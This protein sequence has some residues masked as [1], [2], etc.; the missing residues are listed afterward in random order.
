MSRIGRVLCIVMMGVVLADMALA[1]DVPDWEN[2]LVYGINKE[3]AH[4]TSV[5][6]AKE[7]E[8]GKRSS[9]TRSLD[10]LWKF[11]WAAKPED[12]PIDFYKL[13]Y[14]V[15]DWDDIAVPSNWQRKGYG[16]PVYTN[17]IYPF[18][19]E[20][21]FV[22]KEPPKHY[23]SYELRNPVGSY[24]R[25]FDV[26][27]DWDGKQ[28]FVHFDGVKSTFYLWVNGE[29]V[30]Y[31][32]GSFT[33]AEFDITEYLRDGENMMAVEVYRWSDG[34][35]LEDQDFWRLSGI[36]RPVRLVARNKVAIQDYFVRTD[37]DEE[38]EDAQLQVAVKL[39]NYGDADTAGWTVEGKLLDAEKGLFGSGEI[40]SFA[41][42]EVKVDGDS[43]AEVTFVDDI[44]SPAKWSAEK[45]YLYQLVLT[46]KDKHGKAVEV[47]SCD[48][49]F[50]E[51]E[52]GPN[53][54]LLV[55][56]KSVLLKGV[57]RHEHDPDR[58]RSLTVDS[59]IEDLRLMKLH[60]INCVRTSHYPNDPRWYSLCD[61]YGIYLVDEANIEGHGMYGHQG[62]PALGERRDWDGTH[63]DRAMSMVHRDKNHPS[64]IF[65]SFGNESGG[66]KAFD[67]IAKAIKAVDKTRLLHYEVYWEPADMDSNMYPS[68]GWV[69]SQGKR[70][71]NRPYFVCE[72]A[73][74][75]GN[76]VGNLQEYWDVIERYPRC[77]GACIW[78]WVDQGLRETDENGK[79]YFTY[80]GDY[81]DRPNSGN[82]CINGLIL[83]DR[84]V[85]PKLIEVKQV[86]QY[87]DF[88]AIDAAAG[89]I[90]IANEY[91]FTNLSDFD[92]AWSIT[93][94]GAIVQSGKMHGPDIS[95]KASGEVTLP[96]RQFDA[97]K[98]AEYLLN[99]KLLQRQASDFV[100]RGHTVAQG[101][102]SIPV[103][104]GRLAVDRSKSGDVKVI[105]KDGKIL[106]WG[107]GFT[108]AFSREDATIDELIY[109]GNVVI[110]DNGDGANGPILNAFRAPVDNDNRGNWYRWGLNELK[111]VP[112]SVT[113]DK[114]GSDN[115]AITAVCKYFGRDELECFEV[116]SKYTVF[117]D[118][119]ILVRNHI[120]PGSE[121]GVL[122]RLGMKMHVSGD[123]ENVKWY[124]RGPAENYP[125]RKTGSM[126]GL[127]EST[128]SDQY[129][130]YVRPQTT[131]NKEDVRWAALLNDSGDGV[132]AVSEDVMS[133]TA[134]RYTENE[135]DRAR[136]INELTPR[137]D[138]VVSLDYKQLGLGNGSCGPG[139]LPKYSFPAKTVDFNF[140]LRPY[141][142]TMDDIRKAARGTLT[143][144]KPQVSQN[145]QGDIVIKAGDDV[146]ILYTTDGSDPDADSTEYDEPIEI[147]RRTTVK[148]VAVA[149]GFMASPVASATFYEKLDLVDAG[150]GKWKVVS[151]D[152]VHPGEP[153]S[154]AI[155]GNPGTKWHTEWQNASPPHPHEIVIDM[156]TAYEL[157]G[158][159]LL[160]RQDGSSNGSIKGYKFFVSDDGQEWG[161]PA[162]EG[163]M[164][165]ARQLNTVR[166]D[167]R[168][169]GRYIK[170]VAAS[171]F[172]GPW[173][174][175]AELDVLAT[176]RLD[177]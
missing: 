46:L 175:V 68:I 174:S 5:P 73:H 45:P 26:P 143:V 51:I 122:P 173:T 146:I 132:I 99:V 3:P 84:Q 62:V 22:T 54:Q 35:Y 94:D 59:M 154:N 70:D 7:S 113:V 141:S 137:D 152:S 79:E 56:G 151:V 177:Q 108:M 96:V 25:T 60:N 80:G 150:K 124:G 61:K 148:A 129:V 38:Y 104:M 170:L 169:N 114:G 30:G 16:V 107:D 95:P 131:G 168:V 47:H 164:E 50:R 140:S 153:G 100:P 75:M 157:A 11:H 64:V 20:P 24:R 134:L 81:G 19:K 139:V 89:R 2:P 142:R 33:P 144:P 105:E 71:S 116:Q 145:D 36:F 118:G 42:D 37:L 90:E 92:L 156:G 130:P 58:G 121:M 57:N 127:Y 23:T 147:D 103:K 112:Q 98:G 44:E 72:Y 120:V 158:F 93:E 106:V 172:N 53:G 82:F 34:S 111:C 4:C 83:P 149:E 97:Q 48:V 161:E 69:E 126:I 138:V 40:T 10:G 12:R 125:D 76:A 67:K 128:V 115:V 117:A 43:W 101:Q 135:L 166:F 85:T 110:T 88:D 119:V 165:E 29:K 160:P 63:I 159:A 28:V 15:S 41:I 39:K 167:K 27:S 52:T 18:K 91:H 176:K 102:M 162:G 32:E 74:A 14:D 6:Y 78:D 31:S 13:D 136:H 123:L 87:A 55:N 65:W 86:Y 109:G 171:A 133:F 9:Y 8:I 1:D 77:V 155:D 17:N 21:P 163:V 66:G 49:G